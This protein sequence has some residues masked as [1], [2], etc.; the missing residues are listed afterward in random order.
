MEFS[1][2]S[3]AIS[4][5]AGILSTLS[6]CVLPL[7]P[8]IIGSSASEYKAGPFAVAGGMAFSFAILGTI[9][10]SVGAGIGLNQGSF[11]VVAA[12]LM[13][14][15]GLVL[16][17]KTLQEQFAL[18]I[19]SFGGAGANLLASVTIEGLKGQ[20][21]IGLLLGLVW[22]PCVGPTL[23]AAITIASQG[24]SLDKVV[25]MMTLFGLG[26]GLPVTILSLLS[27]EL[28]LKVKVKLQGASGIGKTVLGVVLVFVGALALSGLDK[29]IEEFFTNHLP[30]QLINLTTAL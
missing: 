3:Y 22:S 29:G 14:L 9:L 18:A 8:I 16:I 21:F 28:M 23:G 24:E 26:A 20:F 1:L 25:L 13:V 4:F 2:S 5:A 7:L 17:S 10:A 6:P 12:I 30:Q 27:R 11:R 15:I 19:S